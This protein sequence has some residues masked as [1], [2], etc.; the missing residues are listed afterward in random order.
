MKV[1]RKAGSIQRQFGMQLIVFELSSCR[2]ASNSVS[3]E[4]ELFHGGIV[5]FW[6]GGRDLGG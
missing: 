2:L 4:P 1:F 5:I 3:I 6:P